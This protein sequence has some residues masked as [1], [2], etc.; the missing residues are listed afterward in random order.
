MSKTFDSKIQEL[1]KEK[2]ELD[3]DFLENKKKEY[4]EKMYQILE[5]P[6]E[7]ENAAEKLGQLRDYH[8]KI[9]DTNQ[10]IQNNPESL[11]KIEQ[12]IKFYEWKK[13]E[14]KNIPLQ[15]NTTEAINETF[16]WDIVYQYA[17]EIWDKELIKNLENRSLSAKKYTDIFEKDYR[18]YMELVYKTLFNS[19]MQQTTPGLTPRKYIKLPKWMIEKMRKDLNDNKSLKVDDVEKFLKNELK[20]NDWKI[21][22]AHIKSTFSRNYDV[23]LKYISS[24]ITN[25]SE[26]SLVDNNEFEKKLPNKR[27]KSKNEKLKSSVSE[28]EIENNR[29]N[30]LNMEDLLTKVFLIKE[31]NKLE[32]R[33]TKYV[34]LFEE[35]WYKFSNREI[36][37]KEIN[38]AI[39][40]HASHRIEKD[41]QKILV[42]TINGNECFEKTGVY[43]YYTF[44]L[45]CWR[46]I[47]WYPNKEI[48]TIC[49][50]EDY[51]HI[52]DYVE[53]PKDKAI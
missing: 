10:K 32:D 44:K 45:N 8:S 43:W 41:I 16:E 11:S 1:E 50:H 48:F 53:P 20:K 30:R 25:Y 31:L 51:D 18:K 19:A 17:K 49:S 29:L 21:K 15:R 6:W 37:E 2:S 5:E 12:K 26:F 7:Q 35:L 9:K 4:E 33:I 14:V 22:I 34:D 27:K 40:C 23:A 24:L 46:R 36:F 47:L 3:L 42:F 39:I 13:E 28:E 52:R 38:E